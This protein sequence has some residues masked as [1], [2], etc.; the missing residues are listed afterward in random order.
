MV[1]DEGARAKVQIE[2]EDEADEFEQE[3]RTRSTLLKSHTPSI[4]FSAAH[5]ASN[6]LMMT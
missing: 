3:L 2:E 5:I 4:K 6:R 1:E